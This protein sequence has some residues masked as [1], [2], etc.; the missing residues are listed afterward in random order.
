M[1]A[2]EMKGGVGHISRHNG[3]RMSGN[4]NPGRVFTRDQLLSRVIGDDAMVTERN[5][6]V[7]IRALRKKLGALREL[8]GTIRRVGY[9]FQSPDD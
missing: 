8:I 1:S 7:H 2:N 3:S 5:I 6:D 9:R 4:D